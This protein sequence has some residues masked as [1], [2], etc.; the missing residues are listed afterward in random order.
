MLSLFG[1]DDKAVFFSSSWA[2][3]TEQPCLLLWFSDVRPLDRRTRWPGW[4]G[5]GSSNPPGAAV[6]FPGVGKTQS[7]RKESGGEVAVVQVG[8]CLRV[9]AGDK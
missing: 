1:H 4:N 8:E 3:G 9:A 2:R 7:R 5:Q 6:L